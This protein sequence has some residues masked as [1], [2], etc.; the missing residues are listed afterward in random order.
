M[1]INSMVT[2][3]KKILPTLFTSLLQ[4][5]ALSLYQKLIQN[6]C[7]TYLFILTALV[8]FNFCWERFIITIQQLVKIVNS[9]MPPEIFLH[10]T[11]D[12]YSQESK[13]LTM[14]CN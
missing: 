2:S 14:I 8:I 4:S 3:S 1:M 13:K 5:L 6:Y 11:C 9:S 7:G 12:L 10:L